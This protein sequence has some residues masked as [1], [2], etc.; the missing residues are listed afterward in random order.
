M[1]YR[2][3]F[4]TNSS[5]ASSVLYKVSI[6]VSNAKNTRDLL[7]YE[8]E[9]ED[10][11]RSELHGIRTALNV[12]INGYN[13]IL[14]AYQ[15]VIL[16]KI[17]SLK[18]ITSEE[19]KQN[20]I[21]IVNDI[22]TEP[23]RSFEEFEN[24]ALWKLLGK[25]SDETLLFLEESLEAYYHSWGSDYDY[26]YNNQ[27]EN[28]KE[29]IDFRDFDKL[30]KKLK[31]PKCN[32]KMTMRV[33]EFGPFYG[34]TNFPKC[35][36]KVKV[37]DRKYNVE[38]D[39]FI[40]KGKSGE[41]ILKMYHG[42]QA[43]VIIPD[44]VNVIGEK[45]FQECRFIDSITIPS[46]V[47]RIEKY[48]FQQCAGI[49]EITIPNSVQFIGESAF[50]WCASLKSIT[51]PDSVTKISDRLFF[52]ID[53]LSEVNLPDT[54]VSMGERVFYNC[55]SLQRIQLPAKITKISAGMFQECTN[56]TEV[57]APGKISEIHEKAFYGCHKLKYIEL[58]PNLHTVGNDALICLLTK[59][60]LIH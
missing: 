7:N 52:S 49:R 37:T 48:A 47:T 20:L 10:E 53:A 46:S 8:V 54:I 12:K 27:D 34:C 1:K 59:K 24:S 26:S 32:K 28:S 36:G 3:D 45:A 30:Y 31:C 58:S 33:S 25:A 15:S 21:T 11:L 38:S 43:N 16:S 50:K 18:N 41:N 23:C 6:I 13:D 42:K 51:I 57:K 60:H 29:V 5:S 9:G 55:Y 39:F 40:V 2:T 35:D 17:I 4:V 44:D 22:V 56:L 19:E 14:E